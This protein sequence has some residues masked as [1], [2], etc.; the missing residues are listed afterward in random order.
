MQ[1]NAITPFN[2]DIFPQY[3]LPQLRYLSMDPV[4]FVRTVAA[5]S[6]VHFATLAVKYLEMGQALRAHGTLRITESGQHYDDN[7]FDVRVLLT[8]QHFYLTRDRFLMIAT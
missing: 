4:V 8:L 7:Q 5:Q 2:G 6:I 3:I 1:V